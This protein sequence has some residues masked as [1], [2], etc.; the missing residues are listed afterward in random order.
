MTLRGLVAAATVLVAVKGLQLAEAFPGVF[1]SVPAAAQGVAPPPAAAPAAPPPA[2]AA[3]A[4]NPQIV[5]TPPPRPAAAQAPEFEALAAQ[6]RGRR[7]GLDHREENL[8]TREAVVAAAERRL[9]QRIE[10]LTALQTRAQQAEAEARERVETHWRGLARLY[11]IM[12][13]REA[14]AVLNELDLSVLA[15]VVDRMGE[16][17]AAPILGA[18]QPERVRQLTIE[19]ARIRAARPPSS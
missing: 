9:V 2:A 15:Q 13:P 6:L 5:V 18:M 11:E 10:E 7:E 19:L 1:L 4:P 17:K 16:R 3:G 12:R 14:A 8:A